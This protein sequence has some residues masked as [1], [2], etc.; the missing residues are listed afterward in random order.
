MNTPARKLSTVR[1]RLR[2]RIAARQRHLRLERE[3]AVY[4]SA[5]DRSELDA[6]LARHTSEQTQE[7]DSIL[8]KQAVRQSRDF[9][10]PPR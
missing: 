2:E 9:T 4:V 8:S 3:L 6:I 5:A 10:R 7:I 1:A